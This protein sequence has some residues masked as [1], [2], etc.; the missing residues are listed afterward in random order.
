[1]NRCFECVTSGTACV[2]GTVGLN[3]VISCWVRVMKEF[4]VG[5]EIVRPIKGRV[6]GSPDAIP[7][8]TTLGYLI[9]IL[10]SR[11]LDFRGLMLKK[12]VVDTS[13]RWYCKIKEWLFVILQEK[14]Q[15][16]M[17]R[18]VFDVCI[19]G[20]PEIYLWDVWCIKEWPVIVP[21][22]N[23]SSCV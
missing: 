7:G 3:K 11:D 5:V 23:V 20:I 10:L 21:S 2:I 4:V 9:P 6:R 16:L 19:C 13:G 17:V 12:D 22:T 18:L 15:F 8:K 14:R 1:M